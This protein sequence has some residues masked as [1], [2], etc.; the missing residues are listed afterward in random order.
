M[1]TIFLIAII[2]AFYTY[3]GYPVFVYLAA[4]LIRWIGP[5]EEQNKEIVTPSITLI[6]TA[7]NEESCIE[8]KIHNSLA[9]SYPAGLL[10]FIFVTDG[11]TDNT[12]GIVTKYPQI[13]LLHASARS[14]KAAAMH[15]AM[16][17]V[18]TELVVFTDANAILNQGAL[19]YI[20]PH[21]TQERTGA[22]AGEKRIDISLV[23]DAVSGE[24][25]YW[26]YE[27]ILKK[28]E[29]TFYSVVGAAGELFSIRTALYEP[30][31]ADTLL[32]DFMI[33]MK[34]AAKGYRIKY[35]PRAFAT[36]K[37]SASVSE[38]RK[39]KV[40]I[41]A[42][43]IQSMLRLPYLLIPLPQP[44]LWFTYISHRILRWVVTPYLLVLAF[45]LNIALAWRDGMAGI[46]GLALVVQLLFYMTALAG[47]LFQRREMPFRLFFAPYYFCLMNYG[48]I[49]GLVCYVF[50]KQTVIWEK[51]ARR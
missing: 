10:H 17:K 34:I 5:E 29:S 39:R 15:R 4:G 27:S 33:S 9:L 12:P 6:V 40:R 25:F 48:M 8:E 13:K 44:L 30:V 19:L 24:G 49:E 3:I 32:D 42:G 2:I 31:P 47:Y 11:S 43:G 16:K 45:I 28:S 23:A 35:E 18:E 22:V 20:I 36:E 26:R 21:Y 14:G 51:A 37:A 41:A 7:Y 38:E 1:Q 50:G 46:T